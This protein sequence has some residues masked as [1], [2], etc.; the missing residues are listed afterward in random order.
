MKKKI[1][2]NKKI[3]CRYGLISIRKGLAFYVSMWFKFNGKQGLTVLIFPSDIFQG[4]INIMR[5]QHT[6]IT[7]LLFHMFTTK[8]S[9]MNSTFFSRIREKSLQT[10]V[11]WS[12]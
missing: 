5:E 1:E 10:F 4:L 11:F 3:K 8:L 7:I 12:K 2:K 6:L 9:H